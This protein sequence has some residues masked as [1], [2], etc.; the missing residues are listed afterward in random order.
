MQGQQHYQHRLVH[1]FD[2]E[3]LI[4]NNHLLRKMDKY[5]NFDFV[6]KLTEPFY[7]QNNGRPSIAPELFFRMVTIGYLYGIQSN[8]Q[9]CEEVRYNLAY[10]W[11]CKLNLEDTVP[12]HSS[13]TRIRDRIGLDTFNKFF[14]KITEQ[15][16][17]VGLVKGERVMTDGTLFQ[18]NASLNSLV[19][20]NKEERNNKYRERG[21]TGIQPPPRRKISNKTHVS[22]TDPDAS[23]A[24]KNGTPRTLK[25][26]AHI[27]MDAD[28]RVILDTKVT[29]GSTH[30][31]QAYLQQIK[32]IEKDLG[33]KI[34][35]ATAD[36][37]YGSGDIIQALINEKIKPNIPLFSGRS[38]TNK[39][40]EGFIYDKENNRYQCPAGNYL[41][42][43]PTIRNATM[44]YHSKSNDCSA[45]QLK[46]MCKAK[47]KFPKEIRILTR[48]VHK[49]LF[50]QVKKSMEEHYFQKNLVERMWKME[51]VIS[52]I[53]QR[54]CLSRAKY[55]GLVNT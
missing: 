7:C 19:P 5:I 45:C 40:P 29:T 34:H 37:A 15:C 2:I 49:E 13:F 52:E 17:E 30:E 42:L 14:L 50:D 20:K 12:D 44:R 47:Q 11:F 9:L 35:E 54:H 55:R 48:H 46:S 41:N 24:F 38:G 43:C 1:Y 22:A 21:K 51:G 18:A 32:K 6:N 26:K 4:P 8:R 39:E 31:S 25:Y 27:T 23:L 10:R 28:S 3:S 16:K 33:I 53:K 36:R